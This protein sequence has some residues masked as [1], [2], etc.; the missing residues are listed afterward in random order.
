LLA[1]GKNCVE[2]SGK[3]SKKTPKHHLDKSSMNTMEGTNIASIFNA[4]LR[5]VAVD[6]AIWIFEKQCGGSS[7]D[8]AL[9]ALRLHESMVLLSLTESF[10]ICR[11][12]IWVTSFGDLSS[13]K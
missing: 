6:L 11:L 7:N 12:C 8:K 9:Q 1:F 4:F 13:E 3:F 2:S 5:N 10:H